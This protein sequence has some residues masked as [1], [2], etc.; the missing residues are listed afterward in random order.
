MKN[1]KSVNFTPKIFCKDKNV[2][3]K[4][5]KPN[6]KRQLSILEMFLSNFN[7]FYIDFI[8]KN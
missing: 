8:H 5:L 3:R 6:I 7:H 2:Q 4:S 1:E